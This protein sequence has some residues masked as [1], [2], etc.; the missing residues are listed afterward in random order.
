[1]HDP[2]ADGGRQPGLHHADHR[3]G[4]GDADHGAD[5]PQQQ[6]DVLLGERVVDQALDEEGLGQTDRGAGHDQADDHREPALEGREQA[7][8]P[9]QRDGGVG[10]LTLVGADL[11]GVGAVAAATAA[12]HGEVIHVTTSILSFDM[13]RLPHHEVASQ[14]DAMLLR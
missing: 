11:G 5:Q 9:A 14:N 8:D 2:L 13:L 6:R 4:G 7:G 1:V 10:E 3:G 12:S